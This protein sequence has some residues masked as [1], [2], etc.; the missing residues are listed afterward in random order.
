VAICATIALESI[1]PRD[2]KR[3]FAVFCATGV[4]FNATALMRRKP[5]LFGKV[6]AISASTVAFFIVGEFP[7]KQ[8]PRGK[9]EQPEIFPIRFSQDIVAMATIVV[10][11][12]ATSV[13]AIVLNV[14]TPYSPFEC[15]YVF[16]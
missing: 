16:D 2:K 11:M 13:E 5:S 14:A 1:L 3:A 7:E 12:R 10:A 6:V 4:A 9:G 15:L 8:K